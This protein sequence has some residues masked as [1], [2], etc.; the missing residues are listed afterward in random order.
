MRSWAASCGLALVS[1]TRGWQNGSVATIWFRV[2]ATATIVTG[3]ETRMVKGR[4]FDQS[5]IRLCVRSYLA[6]NHS[7]RNVDEMMTERSIRRPRDYSWV[8][9]ALLARTAGAVQSVQAS[10]HRPVACRRYIS[11]CAGIGR[12]STLPLT[13][14]VTRSSSGSASNG[15][16]QLPNASGSQASRPA[17]ADCDRRQPD[18]P[19]STLSFD[20]TDRHR[21][22]VR[23][24]LKPIQ[25]RQSRYLNNRIE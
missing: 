8:N 16:W 14:W 24:K 10:R 21:D 7:L 6:Y 25:I 4:H 20:T 15:F 5:V 13:A 19:G 9:R 22:R 2:S 18:E 11:R 3:A 12:I 23:R 1:L 17:R